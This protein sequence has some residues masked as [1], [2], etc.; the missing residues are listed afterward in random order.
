MNRATLAILAGGVSTRMG[1]DKAL[2]DDGRGP[3]LARLASLGLHCD[4][5]VLVIGRLRPPGWPLP[6]VR[7]IPDE[8]PGQG[9]LGGLAT[10]L[11]HAPRVLL[12]ACDLPALTAQAL[13]WLTSLSN[14][15]PLA[16]GLVTER[17]GLIEPLFACYT[18]RCL[19]AVRQRL[20]SGQRALHRLIADGDF[21]RVPLP[22]PLWPALV[23][24][25]TPEDWR[26]WQAGS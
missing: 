21:R 20:A 13:A 7:F 9:P 5:P 1:R 12:I 18:A 3:L 16:D 14:E 11:V 19:P 4:L 6:E 23:N 8:Q 22:A 26:R 15:L 25:N 24:I 2:L 10:A 17:D